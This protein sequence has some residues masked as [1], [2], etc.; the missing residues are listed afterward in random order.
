MLQEA[1][2]RGR[3]HARCA[4]SSNRSSESPRGAT[5]SSTAPPQWRR[6]SATRLPIRRALAS[7]L[8]QGEERARRPGK[9]AEVVDDEPQSSARPLATSALTRTYTR[10]PDVAPNIYRPSEPN[11]PTPAATNGGSVRAPR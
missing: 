6:R 4:L 2:V 7:L 11:A 3:L 9:V 8:S 10:C 1:D 5:R